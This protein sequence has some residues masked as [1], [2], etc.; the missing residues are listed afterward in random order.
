MT[1]GAARAANYAIERADGAASQAWKDEAFTYGVSL[2]KSRRT[3]TSDDLRAG[4]TESTHEYRA[5]GGIMRRLS[6]EGHIERT[7]Q[8]RKSG[9]SYNH[10][11]DLR[12]WR[13]LYA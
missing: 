4:L 1:N 8:T 12:V 7:E 13:S 6:I 2:A 10:N 11:R 9:K 3:F 5:L